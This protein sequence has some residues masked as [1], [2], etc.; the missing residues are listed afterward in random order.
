VGNK[1]IQFIMLS[2]F[3]ITRTKNRNVQNNK[4]FPF[5]LRL[6]IRWREVGLPL[7]SAVGGRLTVEL[8]EF[9]INVLRLH[10]S[11]DCKKVLRRVK[12]WDYLLIMEKVAEA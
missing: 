5:R 9:I 11:I 3:Y 8:M 4:K 7:R 12:V 2:Y 1:I 6:R 10:L